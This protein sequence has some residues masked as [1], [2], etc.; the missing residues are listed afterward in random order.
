METCKNYLQ[1]HNCFQVQ[2]PNLCHQKKTPYMHISEHKF[3]LDWWN[4]DNRDSFSILVNL[5]ILNIWFSQE[6]TFKIY[7]PSSFGTFLLVSLYVLY[8]FSSSWNSMSTQTSE[9]NWKDKCL[10]LEQIIK[11]LSNHCIKG[12]IMLTICLPVCLHIYL[13]VYICNI[14][15][16]QNIN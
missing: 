16:A 6:Y 14:S 2:P 11:T 3:A 5:W 8:Y 1:F 12:R 13:S 15:C 7:V 9:E 4:N 10:E